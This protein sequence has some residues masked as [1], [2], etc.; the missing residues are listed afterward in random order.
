MLRNLLCLIL[1][2]TLGGAAHAES[3]TLGGDLFAAGATA[4]R[5]SGGTRDVF[6]AGNAVG[7]GAAVTRDAHL[8]G[9][10]VDVDRA[11]GGDLYAAGGSVRIA[12]P[13][14]DDLSAAGFSVRTEPGATV[15]GNARLA[16]GSVLVAGPV[17]GALM[18]SGGE[19]TL[20]ASVGGDV[21]AAGSTLVFE[22][23]ATIAGDLTYYAPAPVDV[24]ASV[25]PADRVH[26]IRHDGPT[27]GD[28]AK[29][30]QEEWPARGF[31]SVV[32]GALALLGFFLVIGIFFL[33]VL[34]DRVEALR[35]RII[36]RPGLALLMGVLGLSVLFGLVPVTAMTIIGLP[37][38][39]FVILAIIVYWTLGY[40]LGAYA[41]AMRVL[42][43]FRRAAGEPGLAWRLGALIVGIC[44]IALLNFVPFLGWLANLAL[45]L[46]G[47]G[48]MASAM[49]S[50]FLPRIN[51]TDM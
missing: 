20:A 3:L 24:P 32:A 11:V 2:V 49:A 39:P 19:I 4:T 9:F 22:T 45:V 16:G 10:S 30:W 36:A 33:T 21:V 37:F 50:Q 1:A 38:L 23:G 18:V 12:G 48:A 31:V 14:Q 8:A 27:A 51:G 7:L 35:A 15:G 34:P 43:A 47:I 42:D 6:A 26:F 41:V 13:V 46:L 25:V 5:A 17:S 28:F 29:K 40:L 44:F